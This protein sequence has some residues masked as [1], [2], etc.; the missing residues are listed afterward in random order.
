MKFQDLELGDSLEF[1]GYGNNTQ[2]WME[3]L[4]ERTQKVLVLPMFRIRR[5]YPL[6]NFNLQ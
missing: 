3:V 6:Y 5:V 1:L 2:R 4:N